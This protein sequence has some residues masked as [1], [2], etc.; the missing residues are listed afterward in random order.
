MKGN[1]AEAEFISIPY[2]EVNPAESV[3]RPEEVKRPAAV[4]KLRKDEV[5]LDEKPTAA[6]K[7][8]R[9]VEAKAYSDT[10]VIG[11]VE[12]PKKHIMACIRGRVQLKLGEDYYFGYVYEGSKLSF[13]A[14]QSTSHIEGD[15][16]V[17]TPV[18]LEHGD[19]VYRHG[20]A[21]HRLQSSE[22]GITE[23]RV[24]DM[25]EGAISINDMDPMD[26]NDI[27]TTLYLK[28]SLKKSRVSALMLVCCAFL[29]SDAVCLFSAQRYSSVIETIN[30][31][32][33]AVTVPVKPMRLTTDFGAVMEKMASNIEGKGSYSIA[34]KGNVMQ[35]SITF[36]DESDARDFLAMAGPG[37]RY[38]DGKV[39]IS[40]GPASG[41]PASAAP[42]QAPP[43]GP[44]QPQS[45][46]A[47]EKP[48]PVA[49]NGVVQ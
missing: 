22:T 2:G 36:P 32:A 6:K 8:S 37:A 17:F 42:T 41:Q 33:P 14:T 15:L 40:F 9:R 16:S 47:G 11:T 45:P 13:I 23:Q 43:S 35:F 4:V 44:S 28:W 34:A 30:A 46:V 24:Y 18:L 12:T 19:F 26:K 7:D 29:V 20:A 48:I 10:F 25:P 49:A 39:N 31:K 21:I 5:P 38:E 1:H 3:E 27:P